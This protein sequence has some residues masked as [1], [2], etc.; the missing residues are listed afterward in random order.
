[1]T[2]INTQS[3]DLF[4]IDSVQDLSHEAAATVSGG[5]VVADVVL[6]DRQIG[7]GRSFSTNKAIPDLRKVGFNNIASAVQVTNNQK[8]AFY[9]LPNFKGK[10]EIVGPDEARRLVKL[11][12]RVSSLRAIK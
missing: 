5:A 11:N 2:H 4:A 3:L 1:M 12:N 10:V 8:W 9:D 7:K 6:W